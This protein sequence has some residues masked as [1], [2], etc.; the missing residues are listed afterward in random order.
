[1]E[2]RKNNIYS[3]KKYVSLG[4]IAWALYLMIQAQHASVDSLY[5]QLKTIEQESAMSEPEKLKRLYALKSYADEMPK[6][7]D[8]VYA[9]ILSALGTFELKAN[10]NYARAILFNNE[11]LQINISGKPGTSKKDAVLS[12]L[13]LAYNYEDLLILGKA[14]AYYDTTLQLSKEFEDMSGIYLYSKLS[15]AYIFFR[16]GDYQKCV[17][18][19]FE[20]LKSALLKQDSGYYFSFANQKAQS[21][22]YLDQ[23][24]EASL[25]VEI[26][27]AKA[28][29]SLYPFEVASALKTKAL[30]HEQHKKTAEANELFAEAIEVR[31]RTTEFADHYT[32]LADDYNDWGNFYL[33]TMHNQVKANDCYEQVIKYARLGNDSLRQSKSF[34]NMSKAALMKKDYPNAVNFTLKAM[35]YLKFDATDDILKNPPSNQ[36]NLIGNKDPIIVLMSNKTSLL[37]ELYKQNKDAK[38]L[39][40]SIETALLTDTII[41]QTR[42][43]QSGEQ[44]KLQWRNKTRELFLSAIEAC[45]MANDPEHAFYFMEKS[46]AVLLNDKLNELGASFHLSDADL[47]TEQD[48]KISLAIEQRKLNSTD[49]SSPAYGQ[50]Q[51]RFLQMKDQFEHFIKS[52][53]KNYPTYYQYKYEDKV[54]S[55]GMLQKYL[56]KRKQCFL[57]YFTNDSLAY[58][59]SITAGNATIVKLSKEDFKYERLNQ[60]VQFCANKDSLNAFYPS[61]TALSN[62]IYQSLFQPLQVPA[63]R[64]IVCADNFLVPFEALCRDTLGKDFLIADYTF[65]Y[66]YSAT[67]LLKEA[68]PATAKGNFIGFA[69]VSFK[70]NLAAISLKNSAKALASS[71]APYGSTLLFKNEEA[72]KHNFLEHLGDYRVANIFSH[73]SGGNREEEPRLYMQ[74]SMIYLSDLLLLRKPATSLVVLSACQT[75]VG[76]NATGEGIY[77]LARG[78]SSAGIPSVSATLWEADEEMIY[79]VS[80]KFNRYLSRGMSKDSALHKA[81]LD[82]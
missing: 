24:N 70:A 3:K 14:Q 6:S 43:E 45:Y 12:S 71:A 2:R 51:S 59:L 58:V 54:P 25:D 27:L 44:S 46:R 76:K 52:L 48:F 60:F 77:S 40:A 38:Y 33:N 1:M 4:I 26:I 29:V 50:Q 66:A 35:R 30:I 63:G 18:E 34:I 69:P 31:K 61:F 39:Q 8:S 72:T 78:F 49:A 73:A 62:A 23:L 41:T 42:H 65:S 75:N 64:V 53:E 20:G 47:T 57:H 13:H 36:L 5:Q 74:D 80:E 68:R 21:H 19:S 37:F 79:Q 32:Q 56:A 17:E 11:S 82:F 15:K 7:K 9:K 67:Y 16:M 81:K 28:P 55:L 22:Y 10:K